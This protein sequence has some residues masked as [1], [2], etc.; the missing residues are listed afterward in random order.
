MIILISKYIIDY[1]GD[2]STNQE[3]QVIDTIKLVSKSLTTFVFTFGL[4]SVLRASLCSLAGHC[5]CH[6]H[7]LGCTGTGASTGCWLAPDQ[8]A[9]RQPP[10]AA[11][12]LL[13]PVISLYIFCSYSNVVFVGNRSCS[14]ALDWVYWSSISGSS[15]NSGQPSHYY[16]NLPP[17]YIIWLLYLPECLLALAVHY[18]YL[19]WQYRHCQLCQTAVPN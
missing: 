3:L 12:L 1:Y 9:D 11:A 6:Q 5:W 18:T 7:S 15:R 2:S 17:Y 16:P 19:K 10:A 8:G 14:R 4:W 13:N